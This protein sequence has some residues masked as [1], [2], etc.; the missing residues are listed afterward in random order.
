QYVGENIIWIPLRIGCQQSLQLS[1]HSVL[2]LIERPQT[3]AVRNAVADSISFSGHQRQ[4]VGKSRERNH[5]A[6]RAHRSVS[7]GEILSRFGGRSTDDVHGYGVRGSEFISTPRSSRINARVLPCITV[8]SCL[9]MSGSFLPGCSDST[10]SC[11]GRED[12]YR[13]DD[14]LLCVIVA[15]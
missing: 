1:Q 13:Y 6:P 15:F 4:P 14:W 5:L 3:L 12:Q 11:V 10:I 7:V 8:P 2:R 9:T